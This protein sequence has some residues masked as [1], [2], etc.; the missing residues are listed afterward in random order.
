MRDSFSLAVIAAAVALTGLL[1][2]CKPSTEKRVQWPVMGTVAAV[3]YDISREG[4]VAIIKRVFEL[5]EEKLSAHEPT[6]ELSRL[7]KLSDDEILKMCDERM[8][9]CYEAA[10][11]FR[12]ETNG[13]FNPRWRG[14]GTMDLGAIAKGFAIDLAAS[15]VRASSKSSQGRLLI[16]LGGNLKSVCGSWRI[17]IVSPKDQASVADELILDEGLS[18]ATSAQYYRGRHI[19]DGKSGEALPIDGVSVTVISPNSAMEADALSTIA[20]ILK[21]EAGNWFKTNY[22]SVTL[23]VIEE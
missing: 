10:F 11:R 17:G 16:D 3:N 2:G 15:E 7:A 23:K 13:A 9:P 4:D 14:K 18:C 1:S 6:S 5:V 19:H 21:S 20:Y 8:R 12:D 22:P